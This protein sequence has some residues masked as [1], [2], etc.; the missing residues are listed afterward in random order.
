M[1][2]KPLSEEEK[3]KTAVLT[4]EHT[5]AIQKNE[6]ELNRLMQALA[7]LKEKEAQSLTEQLSR[8]QATLADHTNERSELETVLSNHSTEIDYLQKKL[9]SYISH[10]IEISTSNKK[11]E[12]FDKLSQEETKKELERI[13]SLFEEHCGQMPGI[14]KAYN[15]SSKRIKELKAQ[16]E[17]ASQPCPSSL[18]K[19]GLFKLNFLVDPSEEA[20][21][22]NGR[23]ALM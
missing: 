21:N 23:C 18:A 9:G 11:I 5:A 17:F 10:R 12:K 4:E 14:D 7:Q 3:Q 15:Q 1:I 8:E 6:A 13:V 22:L 19:V 2:S 16:L 20:S